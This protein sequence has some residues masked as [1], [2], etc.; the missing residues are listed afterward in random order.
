MGSISAEDHGAVDQED[1]L[2]V[3]WNAVHEQ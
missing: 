1:A 2:R 3:D